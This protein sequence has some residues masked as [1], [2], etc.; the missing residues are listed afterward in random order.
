V[1]TKTGKTQVR[2]IAAV[3]IHYGADLYDLRVESGART[4]YLLL[5]IERH[6]GP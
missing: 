6:S 4:A 1:D 2:K 5:T 3:L